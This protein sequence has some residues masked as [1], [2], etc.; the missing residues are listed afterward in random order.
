MPA[1]V[2]QSVRPAFERS[3]LVCILLGVVTFGIYFVYW[4][5][6]VF[7]E[8][9]HQEGSSHWTRLFWTQLAVEAAGMVSILA[10]LGR[11]LRAIGDAGSTPAVV[12]APLTVALL[13]VAAALLAVYMVRESSAL[14][15]AAR[16]RGAGQCYPWLFVLVA[17]LG[18]A[19][20]LVAPARTALSVAEIVVALLA[21]SLVQAT[22]NEYWR[23]A[24]A[25]QQEPPA[26]APSPTAAPV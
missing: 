18:V 13:S 3:T 6:R 4:R 9:H 2:T 15:A 17:V 8:L 12:P 20:V 25:S 14:N 1:V 22:L 10:D 19:R 24:L 21:Y 5:H 7:A 26:T 23:R 11:A 16:R